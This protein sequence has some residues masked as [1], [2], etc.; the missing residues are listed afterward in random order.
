MRSDAGPLRGGAN[1]GR[2]GLCRPAPI[3]F[4]ILGVSGLGRGV[5]RSPQN[6]NALVSWK[7][8][9]FRRLHSSLCGLFGSG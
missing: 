8:R 2:V 1:R 9:I 5:Q 3:L 4:W 7:A 6:L